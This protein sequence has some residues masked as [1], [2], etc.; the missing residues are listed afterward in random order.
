[1]A[2][3]V[4]S[5]MRRKGAPATID[6]MF[7]GG[8]V[9]LIAAAVFHYVF[10]TRPTPESGRFAPVCFEQKDPMADMPPAP[11]L[12]RRFECRDGADLGALRHLH[13]SAG[14]RAGDKAFGIAPFHSVR[15]VSGRK[16]HIGGARSVRD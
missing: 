2:T 9:T 16:R 13:G 1:M 15:G 10:L 4:F 3:S 12:D 6:W 5:F 7:L 14:I 11:R 8:G